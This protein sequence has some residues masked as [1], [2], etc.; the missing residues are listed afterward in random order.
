MV[1]SDFHRLLLDRWAQ[2]ERNR[3]GKERNERRHHSID[4]LFVKDDD[5]DDRSPLDL[6]DEERGKS[7]RANQSIYSL[8]TRI[9][10]LTIAT[11][12]ECNQILL[13]VR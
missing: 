10:P 3:Q 6:I 8:A 12:L 2:M 4:V 7:A 1:S 9:S 5:D 11:S 13:R